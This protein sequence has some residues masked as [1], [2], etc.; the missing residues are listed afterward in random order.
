VAA[1]NLIRKTEHSTAGEIPIVASPINLSET[2]ASYDRPPP[3]L[4][5]H[6]DEVLKEHL[7]LDAEAISELRSK[8]ILG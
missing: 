4:G 2:P 1:R 6:T 3:L 8:G 5:E 7:G